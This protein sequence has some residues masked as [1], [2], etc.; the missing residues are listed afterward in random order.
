MKKISLF[1]LM[2][3]CING[4]L[5]SN[6]KH[7]NYV[8]SDMS[9]FETPMWVFDENLEDKNDDYE[10][11]IS[12]T[13]DYDKTLCKKNALFIATE[14]IVAKISKDI[15]SSEHF[16]NVKTDYIKNLIRL[17][18]FNIEKI[19]NYWE[20]KKYKKSF[21]ANDDYNIYSCYEAIKI[22]K[23]YLKQ[24]TDKVLLIL[25]KHN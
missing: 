20:Q 23:E 11:F 12:G 13:D 8:I 19:D 7:L 10:Y 14:K 3:V 17:N 2:L 15:I 22:K 6:K 21:G 24:I 4:C 25:N 16:N 5:F 9:S 18:L 1:I